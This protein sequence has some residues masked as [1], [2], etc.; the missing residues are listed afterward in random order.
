MKNTTK[1]EIVP[2]VGMG[3][4]TGFNGDAYPYTVVKVFS[5]KKIAVTRDSY[6]VIPRENEP[7]MEGPKNCK[8]TT[9]WDGNPTIVTKRKN[10]RW[11]EQGVDLWSGWNFYVGDR[12]YAQ[13]PHF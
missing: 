4:Y 1:E 13:N 11:V 5:P 7:Y 10:G 2:T 12:C 8:F 6:E 3:A 9:N